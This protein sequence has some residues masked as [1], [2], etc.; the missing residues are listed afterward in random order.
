MERLP[1]TLTLRHATPSDLAA[2]DALLARSYPRLLAADYPPSV[3]VTAVPI[4]AR[5]RP[6]LLASGR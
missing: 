6:E 1:D 2:V 4:I 5:A 3:L